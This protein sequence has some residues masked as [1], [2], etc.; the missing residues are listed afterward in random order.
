MAST[1]DKALAIKESA[2]R[3]IA[4]IIG[5]GIKTSCIMNAMQAIMRNRDELALIVGGAR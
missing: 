4:Q 2:L 5:Y 1:Q 3:I